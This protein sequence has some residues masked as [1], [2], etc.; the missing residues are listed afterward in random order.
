[1]TIKKMTKEHYTDVLDMMRVFYD[2]PAVLH[3]SSD[4][5][6]ENDINACISD[7]VYLDGYVFVEDDIITGYAMVSKSFTTEY[8]GICAW[9]EDLYIKPEF[10]RKGYARQ[11]FGELPSLSPDVVRFKLE[12]EPENERAIATYNNCDYS[13][14]HYNIMEMVMIED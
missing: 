12:V 8:G 11:F 4:K 3:T 14:L 2:S 6:L 5:V 13:L 9:I 1:M 10:R 7:N